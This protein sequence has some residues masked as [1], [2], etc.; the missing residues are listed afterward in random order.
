MSAHID[1]TLDSSRAGYNAA[2]PDV[3]GLFS[4]QAIDANDPVE[5]FTLYG[6]VYKKFFIETLDGQK[7][8]ARKRGF[9][10]TAC[11]AAVAASL[12]TPEFQFLSAGEKVQRSGKQ[13]CVK[14][15]TQVLLQIPRDQCQHCKCHVYLAFD[16]DVLCDTAG[17]MLCVA[18][19]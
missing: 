12:E 2:V 10:T 4:S 6:T 1:A 16:S 14:T 18:S 8:V 17:S 11:T 9:T 13:Q 15:E 5:P 3:A 19:W 7:V